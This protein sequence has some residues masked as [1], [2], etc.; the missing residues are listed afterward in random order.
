MF[1]L[2]G[3][4][5]R[6]SLRDGVGESLIRRAVISIAVVTT[7]AFSGQAHA[8]F[9][10]PLPACDNVSAVFRA[11]TPERRGHFGIDYPVPVGTVV[12]ASRKGRVLESASLPGAGSFLRIAH[13]DGYETFYAH[14]SERKV[15]V[16]QTV[17]AGQAIALSGDSGMVTGP[18]LHFEV[19]VNG[20]AVDPQPLYAKPRR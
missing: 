7:V 16:G 3:L 8:G 20:R 1:S 4:S 14:L 5:L 10:C 18:A 9:L 15:A 17:E 11:T 12:Q 19:R 13:A 2:L 6:F